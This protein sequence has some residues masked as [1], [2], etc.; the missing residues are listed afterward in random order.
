[1]TDAKYFKKRSKADISA[2]NH[3]N[4]NQNNNKN[5]DNK[6]LNIYEEREEDVIVAVDDYDYPNH[7]HNNNKK[8]EINNYEYYYIETAEIDEEEKIDVDE[9]RKKKDVTKDDEENNSSNQSFIA[10]NCQVK[11]KTRN[12]SEK[13]NE[14]IKKNYINSGEFTYNNNKNASGE[15]SNDSFNNISN[16]K[17]APIRKENQ[18]NKKS[19]VPTSE[20]SN[21][22]FAAEASNLPIENHQNITEVSLSAD[23]ED[24]TVTSLKK[25]K[26]NAHRYRNVNLLRERTMPNFDRTNSLEINR[27]K[28]G[29]ADSS[30]NRQL[31]WVN[32]ATMDGMHNIKSKNDASKPIYNA[33]AS[34]FTAAKN[35]SNNINLN[36]KSL[37][38]LTSLSASHNNVPVLSSEKTD[39]VQ[40]TQPMRIRNS[41]KNEAVENISLNRPS[42]TAHTK[43]IRAEREK[44]LTAG[45]SNAR[46]S[47]SETP[48]HDDRSGEASHTTKA[49]QI[50]EINAN[51]VNKGIESEEV[52]SKRK[53]KLPILI[54]SKEETKDKKSSFDLKRL[55][56][57]TSPTVNVD[58]SQRKA[59]SSGNASSSN[60]EIKETKGIKVQSN[61]NSSPNLTSNSYLLNQ[62]VIYKKIA[63]YNQEKSTRFIKVR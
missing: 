38:F 59:G 12:I 18:F 63:D 21:E 52:S 58:N 41:D 25:S 48:P 8:N 32:I 11:T 49:T 7:N 1:M 15:N 57:L 50:T 43:R 30:S 3:K 39:L 51:H 54:A 6:I 20:T 42:Y 13:I 22:N 33:N 29:N 47:R 31:H 23:S 60:R 17:L 5:D 16:I 37:V 44:A 40:L 14:K 27:Q 24:D 45:M 53:D 9:G 36:S 4:S 26:N 61:A 56:E 34:W 2:C 46:E 19:K 55:L 10:T 28:Y 35:D 62:A